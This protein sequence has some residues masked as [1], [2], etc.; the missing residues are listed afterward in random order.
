[1]PD[2]VALALTDTLMLAWAW[3]ATDAAEAKHTA[4]EM[5]TS[6]IALNASIVLPATV[7]IGPVSAIVELTATPISSRCA[8]KDA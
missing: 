2:T 3:T 6:P 5:P 1:L 7:P 4:P 8:W